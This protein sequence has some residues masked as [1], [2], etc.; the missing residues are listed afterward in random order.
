MLLLHLYQDPQPGTNR[1]RAGSATFHALMVIDFFYFFK[2]IF[3]KSKGRISFRVIHSD[4]TN[5]NQIRI[6]IADLSLHCHFLNLCV[7][8]EACQRPQKILDPPLHAV[9]VVPRGRV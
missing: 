4:P 6:R 7:G 3:G 1:K 9:F 5:F 8:G 2:K